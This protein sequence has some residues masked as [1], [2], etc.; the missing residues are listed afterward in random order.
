M[1]NVLAFVALVEGATGLKGIQDVDI[2]NVIMTQWWDRV[3]LMFTSLH[4][5]HHSLLANVSFIPSSKTCQNHN[6]GN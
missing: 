5:I 4:I 2:W 3:S 1:V 6:T